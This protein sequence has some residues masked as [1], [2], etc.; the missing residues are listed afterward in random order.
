M[1]PVLPGPSLSGSQLPGALLAVPTFAGSSSRF[2]RRRVLTAG[3]AL[4]LTALG[5]AGCG[6]GGGGAPGGEEPDLRA[7]LPRAAPGPADAAAGLVGP[8]ATTLLGA[9]DRS[10]ANAVCSPLSA[11]IA[12]TM[13]GMGAAGSTR[14]QM[15]Q[16]LGGPMDE[17]ASVANTLAQLLADVGDAQRETQEDGAPEPA[18]ASLVNGTWLQE[19]MAVRE[20]FLEHLA[21][22]FGSGLFEADFVD[23]T[24][25]EDARQEINSW[26]AS[27]TGGLIPELVPDG[28]L[29]ADTRMVLVNALHLKAAWQ[30]ELTRMSGTF[31]TS[32]AEEVGVDML[33]GA[34][35]TWYEDELC[36]ATSL[37]TYGEQLALALV[38]PVG[39]L[40][41]LLD[42]WAEGAA[43]PDSGLQAL[44]TG[45][46][47]S[48]ATVQLSVPVFDIG[49]GDSL[50]ETL[51]ALGMADAFSAAA[52]FSGVTGERDL[53]IDDVL[54]KA[55]LTIDEEG[56]EAAAATAV[57]VAE[58]SAQIPEQELVLDSPFLVVAFERSTLAPLVL[59]WIGDPTQTR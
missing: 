15:E 38:Q 48:R 35:T 18:V 28:A 53:V 47:Q 40:D 6:A 55:V 8:F 19:G 21:V 56:M 11:Q 14:A 52:D 44:L 43:G 2:P 49:W 50:R 41:E 34:T 29:R 22:W 12:L 58:T 24:A 51:E 59:G 30:E 10:P 57:I 54:Q 25:R 26:V 17:L 39:G 45:L 20:S 37:D 33:G 1:T 7:E 16:V 4:P 23:D 27:S 42:A 13:I 5:L 3:A 46:Q 31:T 9:I 36:R 32:G